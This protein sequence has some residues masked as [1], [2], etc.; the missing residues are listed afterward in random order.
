MNF[1]KELSQGFR[2]SLMVAIPVATV[3]GLTALAYA[4]LT[5]FSAGQPLS[6][7]TMNSNFSGL[8]MRIAALEAA[9]AQ[10][11]DAGALASAGVPIGTVVAYPGPLDSTHLAPAGWLP[12]DGTSLDGTSAKYAALYA[13]IG[14]AHGGNTTSQQFNLPDYRGY[15]LRGLDTT[16]AGSNDPDVDSRVALNTGGNTGK[17]VGSLET[18]AFGAHSHGVNDPGHAHNYLNYVI[19]GGGGGGGFAN[20]SPGNYPTVTLSTEVAGTGITISAAGGGETR[21]K[22]VAVNYIIKY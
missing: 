2:R 6:S 8:D 17:A 3:V 21:P 13:V 7:A 20:A 12:C 9:A 18:D 10:A 5:T 4:G 1:K 14:V 19:G 15:F 16:D 11:A 22:N